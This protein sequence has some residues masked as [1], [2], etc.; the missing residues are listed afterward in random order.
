MFCCVV[1]CGVF[2]TIDIFVYDVVVVVVVIFI[3]IQFDSI[4]NHTI[5]HNIAPNPISIPILVY[6]RTGQSRQ[7]AEI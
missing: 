2:L 5:Q 3:S 6:T 7:S 1:W 4:Q